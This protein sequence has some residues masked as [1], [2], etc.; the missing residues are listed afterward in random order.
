MTRRLEP[1]RGA[2]HE[3]WAATL[4]VRAVVDYMPGTACDELR[5]IEKD[6][7]TDVAIREC[8]RRWH[9][10]CPCMITWAHGDVIARSILGPGG[11]L[12]EG[13]SG[14]ALPVEWFETLHDLNGA[15]LDVY[16]HDVRAL[17]RPT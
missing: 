1:A 16:G 9:V 3:A 13:Y 15:L 4:F 14:P 8:A 17:D 12:G 10:E 5:A 7:S 6:D 2:E 11:R